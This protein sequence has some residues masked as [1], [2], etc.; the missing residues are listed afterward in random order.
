[1]QIAERMRG[2]V[3]G[4]RIMLSE[5]S[6]SAITVT[7]CFGVAFCEADCFERVDSIIKSADDALYRAKAEGRNRVC[8]G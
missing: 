7:A 3:E 1:M 8:R 2:N 5:N 4:I 6:P